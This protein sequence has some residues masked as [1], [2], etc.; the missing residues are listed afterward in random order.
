MVRALVHNLLGH[1]GVLVV[2][3][4]TLIPILAMVAQVTLQVQAHLKVTME[5]EARQGL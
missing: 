1:Q 3:V 4:E 2:A 5:V